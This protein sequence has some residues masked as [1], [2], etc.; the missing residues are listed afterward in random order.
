MTRYIIDSDD[1]DID[2]LYSYLINNITFND[3]LSL[4]IKLRNK[5]STGSD[6]NE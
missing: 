4:Y 3:L 5:I 2:S 6:D 1:L